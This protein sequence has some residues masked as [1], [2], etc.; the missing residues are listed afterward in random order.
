M[1]DTI[2]SSSCEFHLIRGWMPARKPY[3]K[4]SIRSCETVNIDGHAL[5]YTALSLSHIRDDRYHMHIH[6]HGQP[7][8]TN[9]TID[10]DK[11]TSHMV[12]IDVSGILNVYYYRGVCVMILHRDR[13]TVADDEGQIVG[14]V[15]IC[16]K[17]ERCKNGFNIGNRWSQMVNEWL[18]V[19]DF[20]DQLYRVNLMDI[21]EKI[22]DK[23]ELMDMEVKDFWVH[24]NGNIGLLYINGFLKVRAD[25]T[26]NLMAA[27]RKVKWAWKHNDV[28]KILIRSGKLWIVGGDKFGNGIIA[29]VTTSGKVLSNLSFK[30]TSN[31][32]KSIY[33]G[34]FPALFCLKS[35][36]NRDT[37]SIILAVERDVCYHLL[38]IGQRGNIM[39]ITS[40]FTQPYN[41]QC[42]KY[43][44]LI[45]AVSRICNTNE[46]L[47]CGHSSIKRLTIDIK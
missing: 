19:I 30:I 18:F 8:S 22:Y 39:I 11:P 37:R 14:Y 31:G 47:I 12:D 9:Y 3:L 43:L 2:K 20:K 21:K 32:H 4:A 1:T 34:K 16:G 46:Y 36:Y 26:V 5:N 27:T 10:L 38:T 45:S 6:N 35:V 42:N 25:R 7:W 15:G 29:S 33:L 17:G 40:V 41:V 28:W 44:H 24:T 23:K 13:V